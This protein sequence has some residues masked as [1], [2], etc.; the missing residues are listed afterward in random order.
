LQITGQYHRADIG[1]KM[2]NPAGLDSLPRAAGA[3][4]LRD[5]EHLHSR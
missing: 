5:F 4:F 2:D 1:V 3:R